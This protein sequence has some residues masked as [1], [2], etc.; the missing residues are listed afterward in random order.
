MEPNAFSITFF[1]LVILRPANQGIGLETKVTEVLVPTSGDLE[2]ECKVIFSTTSLKQSNICARH[3]N[4]IPI[5]HIRSINQSHQ[6]MLQLI[7]N[8]AFSCQVNHQVSSN[9]PPVNHKSINPTN[10]LSNHSRRNFTCQ[11]TTIIIKTIQIWCSNKA[12]PLQGCLT[13]NELCEHGMVTKEKHLSNLPNPRA[14]T[15]V[16]TRM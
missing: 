2:K 11:Q 15:S 8:T 9:N 13:N 16:A 10:H 1:R 5:Y 6:T 14:A 12:I 4:L 7:F 3:I